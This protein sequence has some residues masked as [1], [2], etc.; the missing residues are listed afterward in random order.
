MSFILKEINCQGS[1]KT[2][3]MMAMMK[4]VLVMTMKTVWK[5]RTVIVQICYTKIKNG[6]RYKKRKVPSIIRYVRYNK[7]SDAKIT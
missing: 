7:K 1:W 3:M 4:I 6:I 2:K 5:M